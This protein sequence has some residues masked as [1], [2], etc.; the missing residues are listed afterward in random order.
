MTG[1]LIPLVAL[2]ALG[3]L[4][5]SCAIVAGST[6]ETVIDT[7]RPERQPADDGDAPPAGTGEPRLRVITRPDDALVSIDNRFVGR[8][9]LDVDDIAP[10]RYWLLVEKGGF[11]PV[12]RRITID[13]RRSLVVELDLKQITGFLQVDTDPAATVTVGS[14][15][16]DDGFAE[17]P[18]GTYTVRVE[19]FGYEPQTLRAAVEVDRVTRL[20]VDLN[21]ALFDV[22]GYASSRRA[23]N[24]DNPGL[25]GTVT[26]RFRVTAPGDGTIAIGSDS[27]AIVRSIPVGP[28]TEWDQA[29]TWDGSDADG[30]RVPDGEYQI[31]IEAI[32]DSGERVVRR[33]TVRV[34]GSL[35][36]RYRSIWGANAGL[37]YVPTLEPLP[38]GQVQLTAQIAGAALPT[39]GGWVG[40]FPARVGARVGI[41]P[42]AELVVHGGAI[43]QVAPGSERW[44]AGAA[45]TWVPLQP[46][47]GGPGSIAI[48]LS[49]GALYQSPIAGRYAAPDSQA[50]HA[51][52]F[53]SVPVS[54]RFAS[55]SATIA[56]EARLSPAPVW[57]G[58]LPR[59]DER[60][61]GFGYLR[62]G[63]GVD[64]GAVSAGLSG[65][66]RTST[67]GGPLS[68]QAP[69]LA[70]AEAHVI[71]P[72][73]PVVVSVIA[74]AEIE[75]RRDFYVMGGI[76]FGLLF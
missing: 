67:F 74:A 25:T 8:T 28:F 40:R 34:D 45:A 20:S 4:L 35:V 18:V 39:S 61:V 3:A 24:P 16:L 26:V 2:I 55:V 32:G 5:G 10:G 7:E 31:T 50:S 54:L 75:S 68:I 51:G 58:T 47:F 53:A 66:L 64:V 72:G 30:R 60:W 65:A 33:T 59:P 63:V 52:F 21:P 11:Y 1:V 36:V 12:E 22:D 37:L 23:F 9:P 6:L 14:R 15:S 73:L 43:I 62:Y 44:S 69:Y 70:G 76:G 38:S 29:A 71:L 46:R 49:G 27:N 19:R 42:A 57:Y 17:L 41:G 13:E 48:G 56:P